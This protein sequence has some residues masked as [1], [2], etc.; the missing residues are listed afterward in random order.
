MF[1]SGL[2]QKMNHFRGSSISKHPQRTFCSSTWSL[3]NLQPSWNSRIHNHNLNG[4]HWESWWRRGGKKERFQIVRTA[5]SEPFLSPSWCSSDGSRSWY[6]L[7]AAFKCF[8]KPVN[9]NSSAFFLRNCTC[10]RA[11]L[12]M[13]SWTFNSKAAICCC[14]ATSMTGGSTGSTGSMTGSMTGGSAAHA[15]SKASLASGTTSTG[16]STEGSLVE[17][18][19]WTL[20]RKSS[21]PAHPRP[22]FLFAKH[23]ST[24]I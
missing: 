13:A 19:S 10:A 14:T 9:S 17:S 16:A 21:Y 12:L 1:P 5:N 24:D 4:N 18:F 23:N 2:L 6:T 7:H 15:A 11:V 3:T 8:I 20:R 22:E